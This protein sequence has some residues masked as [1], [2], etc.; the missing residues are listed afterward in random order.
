MNT[1]PSSDDIEV[2]ANNAMLLLQSGQVMPALTAWRHLLSIRTERAEDWFNLAWLERMAGNADNALAAYAQA[3]ALG[4]E[5]PEEVHINQ[6]A[7]HSEMLFEPEA[8]EAALATALRINAEFLPA[9]LNLGNLHEDMGN[10][11]LARAAYEEALKTVPTN[12][13]ALARIAGIDRFQGAAAVALPRIEAALRAPGLTADDRLELGFAHGQLLDALGRYDDAFDSFSAANDLQRRTLPRYDDMVQTALID[14]LTS[15][16][17]LAANA[18][19]ALDV[20]PPIFICGLF[21]SGSTLVEQMLGRHSAV[22]SGGELDTLP[23]LVLQRLQPYPSALA[24]YDQA[25]LTCLR[26]E[27]DEALRR[28]FPG[29][30]KITDKRP[31][32]YLHIGLIKAIYPDARIIHTVRRPIDIFL[33]TYFLPFGASV[34][35]GSD[36]DDMLDHYRHY[37]RLM[38]HWMANYKDDIHEISYD[39]LVA[40]PR[41]ELSRLLI[42]L[43]LDWEDACLEPSTGTAIRTASVWQVRQ[44]LHRQSSGRSCNY[45]SQISDLAAILSA[46]FP[47][48]G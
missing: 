45:A 10:A 24:T 28:R 38:A 17:P 40:D 12:G 27:Y 5:R 41:I 43:G 7:I 13:R 33:S 29:A 3:L 22:T 19:P 20:S 32:N 44:P 46:E 8:A 36:F 9:W 48:R 35:Y 31:D 18:P 26:Q 39:S 47:E 16:M 23:R 37:R 30:G 14:A 21:R 4:I 2:L 25:A 1:A 42:F 34:T 6:A 15:Q 11:D